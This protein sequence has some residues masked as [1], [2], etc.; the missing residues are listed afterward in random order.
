MYQNPRRLRQPEERVGHLT[1]AALP[2][3]AADFADTDLV[4][5][6]RARD[7]TVFQQL[8]HRYYSSMLRVAANFVRST[9]EAEE[10]IQETW[11]AVMKGIDRFQG[12]S[13][14]QTWIFRIL[15]NRARTRA[16]REARVIP[17]GALAP[18][19]VDEHAARF[20][21]VA[22]AWP[23]TGSLA[24]DPEQ[25]LLNAELRALLEQAIAKLP[26]KQR[27]VISLRDV[28]GWTADEVC[29]ALGVNDSNQ[30]VLLHRARLKVRAAIAGYLDVVG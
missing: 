5:R 29:H 21:D 17:F 26:R 27:L 1:N 25:M 24:P 11:I 28:E 22:T 18:A 4:A 12:R 15:I 3:P 13:S 6:M 30:R 14:L 20:E 8:I 7:E 19:H 16:R 10:V 2:P 23:G 9:D